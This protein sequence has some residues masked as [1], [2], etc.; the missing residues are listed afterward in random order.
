MVAQIWTFAVSATG[1]LHI[2]PDVEMPE[3]DNVVCVP[4]RQDGDL[5]RIAASD[6]AAI[7]QLIGSET[8]NVLVP[9]GPNAADELEDLLT[10]IHVIAQARINQ[11][12]G[13]DDDG[14]D[15]PPPPGMR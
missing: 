4:V 6:L 1:E 9:S 12:R 5:V 10:R 15:A 2:F 7:R 8:R 3:A 13:D 14:D 11:L